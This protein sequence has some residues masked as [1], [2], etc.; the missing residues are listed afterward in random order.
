M[1]IINLGDEHLGSRS[2]RKTHC[3][4]IEMSSAQSL[5]LNINSITDR[6]LSYSHVVDDVDS[7]KIYWDKDLGKMNFA[8]ILIITFWR[9][10]LKFLRESNMQ[11]SFYFRT[12]SMFNITHNERTIYTAYCRRCCGNEKTSKPIIN[13]IVNCNNCT[14]LV[15]N[16]VFSSATHNLY[17]YIF[18]CPQYIFLTVDNQTNDWF[19]PHAIRNAWPVKA[20]PI[21][22]IC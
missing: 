9:K 1:N 5:S 7:R 16:N 20:N 15:D 19:E 21:N 18:I 12:F 6:P 10:K 3:N 11:V 22:L 2:I 4:C 14:V 13:L 8:S 17:T